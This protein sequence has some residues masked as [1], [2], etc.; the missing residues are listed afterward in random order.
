MDLTKFSFFSAVYRIV[1]Q[2]YGSTLFEDLMH[3]KIDCF[4]DTLDENLQKSQV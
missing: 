2:G 4:I 1:C 3:K